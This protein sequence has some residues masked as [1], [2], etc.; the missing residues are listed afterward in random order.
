M[1]AKPVFPCY[2]VEYPY[3]LSH[4]QL[5]VEMLHIGLRS[6][7]FVLECYFCTTSEFYLLAIPFH[8]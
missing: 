1:E 5:W 4:I 8:R 6:P 3:L 7:E 2:Q